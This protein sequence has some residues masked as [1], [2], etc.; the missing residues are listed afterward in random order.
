M[1]SAEAF[2]AQ[3]AELKRDGEA[4]RWFSP[5]NRLS[6]VPR[7]AAALGLDVDPEESLSDGLSLGLEEPSTSDQETAPGELS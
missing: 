3:I 7:Y 2:E 5:L 6:I 1:R 4:S